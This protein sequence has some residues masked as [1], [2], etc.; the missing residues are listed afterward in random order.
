[1]IVDPQGAPLAG[2]QWWTP[3]CRRVSGPS[4]RSHQ[5]HH[6]VISRQDQV[7]IYQELVSAPPAKGPAQCGVGA[8]PAGE[9]TTSFLS[10]CARVKDNRLLPE[11]YLKLDERIAIARA[12]GAGTDLAHEAGSLVDDPDYLTG[13]GDTLV[14]RVPLADLKGAR[15]AGVQA[16]V[17]YQATPPYYLQDRFCTA[18]GTD[19]E[20]LYQLAGRLDLSGT[21]AAGWKLKV[22][23]TP[24]VKVQ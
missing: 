14:Y 13:G 15:P 24:V 18:R 1:M 16:T 6:Q 23:Q 22:V 11:G 10:I 8:A 20:R 12:L 17:Y 19:T 2:E 21:P 4:A 5:P 3:D 7:Q 9:L